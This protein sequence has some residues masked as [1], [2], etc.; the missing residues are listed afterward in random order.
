MFEPGH[1]AILGLNIQAGSP[2]K[3]DLSGFLGFTGIETV[4][5]IAEEDGNEEWVYEIKN[6][7]TNSDDDSLCQTLRLIK[8]K[9]MSTS[10][11]I[12]TEVSAD[13]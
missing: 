10:E 5:V 12:L 9:Q 3:I 4:T 6:E 13:F 1:P 11:E 2:V 7:V 8:R